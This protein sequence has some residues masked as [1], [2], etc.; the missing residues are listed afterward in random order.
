MIFFGAIWLAPVPIAGEE[1]LDGRDLVL[2][3][4]GLGNA[5]A[6]V[7]GPVDRMKSA[8]SRTES[9]LVDGSRGSTPGTRGL[10][11]FGIGFDWD[12]MVSAEGFDPCVIVVGLVLFMGLERKP[13]PLNLVEDRE[14]LGRSGSATGGAESRRKSARSAVPERPCFCHFGES[15]AFR[16]ISGEG[17][18]GGISTYLHRA[19]VLGRERVFDRFLTVD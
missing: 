14:S 11:D 13:R 10:G 19:H 12:L 5:L 15:V 2:D 6:V 16:F 4:T 9:L 17:E 1:E 18:I 7:S 3:I 8:K